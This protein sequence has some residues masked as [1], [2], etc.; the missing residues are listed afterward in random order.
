M[1][2]EA[3]G[4]R[5]LLSFALGNPPFHLNQALGT[6]SA[7]IWRLGVLNQGSAVFLMMGIIREMIVEVMV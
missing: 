6:F 3:C 2:S 7:T 4:A 5:G 1:V